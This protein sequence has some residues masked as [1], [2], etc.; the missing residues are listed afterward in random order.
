MVLQ[1]IFFLNFNVFLL[2]RYYL[3]LEKGYPFS[4]NKLESPPPK[5]D[6]RQVWLKLTPLL[7]FPLEEGLS[8]SFDQT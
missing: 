7:L 2:F 1:K 5:D 8:P 4:L 3:P 6:L